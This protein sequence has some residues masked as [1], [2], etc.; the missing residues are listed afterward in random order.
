MVDINWRPVFWSQEET[1]ARQ[2]ILDYARRYASFVKIT[3]EEAEWMFPGKIRAQEVL[4]TPQ[5][6]LGD[7]FFPQ[8][9]LVLVTAGEKGCGGATREGRTHR[10]EAFEVDAVET[11]GAGD[12]FS[13]GILHYLLQ[14]DSLEDFDLK[15]GLEF[16]SA[17]GALV[18][19]KYGAWSVPHLHEVETL[20]SEASRP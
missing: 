19:T 7:G 11:T 10:Q 6:L 14:L 9:D 18:T 3:D 2:M 4:E 16:A 17:V 12:A 5:I 13:A 8:A 1:H 15:E 20:V